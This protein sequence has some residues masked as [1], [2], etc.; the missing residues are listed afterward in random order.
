MIYFS[1][2]LD[3]LSS[4]GSLPHLAQPCCVALGQA[5]VFMAV[6]RMV[7]YA[8]DHDQVSAIGSWFNWVDLG[9]YHVLFIGHDNTGYA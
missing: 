7:P 3:Q 4:D 9:K 1:L 6:S 5:L 2:W 8:A